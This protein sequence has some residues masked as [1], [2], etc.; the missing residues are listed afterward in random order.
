MKKAL[1]LLLV[2]VMGMSVLSLVAQ[3]D[4]LISQEDADLFYVLEEKKLAT[5]LYTAFEEAW[6]NKFS[7]NLIMEE[8]QLASIEQ[9]VQEKTLEVPVSVAMEIEGQFSNADVQKLQRKLLP[10]INANETEALKALAMLEET[11]IKIMDQA[12]LNTE[13][14]DLII[15]YDRIRVSARTQLVSVCKALAEEGVQYQP[16]ALTAKEF[17]AL[18]GPVL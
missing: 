11:E 15:L 10:N 16:K 14:I 4:D 13:N 3:T 17:K 12:I 5:E 6:D 9:E 18:I 7:R 2:L 1:I 8:Q